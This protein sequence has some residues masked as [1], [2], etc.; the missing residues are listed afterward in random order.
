MRR[1]A[2]ALLSIAAAAL[3]ACG[4]RASLPPPPPE[5]EEGRFSHALHADLACVDCHAL[6]AV[7]AGRPARPGGDD[8]APCDLGECHQAAFLAAPGPLCALCH[9]Q[10]DPTRD[11]ATTLAPY[12]PRTGRRALA[13]RF[14]HA[15]HLDLSAIERAVGFHVGCSDCHAIDDA[16]SPAAA[17]HAVCGR[18]HAP[19]AAPAGTP[20]LH[21]CADC[22]ADRVEQPPR[23]RRFIVGDLR[24]GHRDHLTD[25]RGVPIRCVE[26]HAGS[27]E[28]DAAGHHAPPTTAACVACH[29]DPARTPP[30]MRMRMCE[31]CHATRVSSF[32]AIAPRSHLPA[33]ERPEDHT[34]AFR[35]DHAAD[36]VADAARCARCHTYV[37]GSPRDTCDQCHQVMRPRDHDVTWR[38]FE[39]GAAA[40]ADSDRCS[41]CHT[42]TSCV[43]C[44]SVPPRSHLPLLEFRGRGHGPLARFNPRACV[45][46]HQPEVFCASCHLGAGP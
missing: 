10:V 32:G 24:F 40:A 17:D 35:R 14:S 4:G 13:S 29:D 23:R 44:H 6:D 43:A 34:L 45:T 39:H 36:A 26:C 5:T 33:L 31:T 41:T 46:C 3:I 2:P 27:V 11:G 9:D 7:L 21:R 37:S 38:E 12:P 16:G 22:H 19:E 1:A 42:G 30:A 25:R 20:A 18:C 15:R 28:A 8:H